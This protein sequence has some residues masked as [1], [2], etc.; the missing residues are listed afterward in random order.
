[1][2]TPLGPRP[3]S[4]AENTLRKPLQSPGALGKGPTCPALS[5][6]WC[7]LPLGSPSLLASGGYVGGGEVGK[8]LG[9]GR[10]PLRPAHLP[11]LPRCKRNLHS[12]GA[13]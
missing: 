9:A 8:E 2:G 6:A 4:H 10:C 5:G 3:Q 13:N 7:P 1:M 12:E 11:F